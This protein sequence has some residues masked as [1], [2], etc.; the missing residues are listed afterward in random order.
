MF[1]HK[2]TLLSRPASSK[3]AESEFLPTWEHWMRHPMLDEKVGLVWLWLV[4]GERRTGRTLSEQLCHLSI[5]LT[6]TGAQLLIEQL[7]VQG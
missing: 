6:S 4:G 1:E 5:G 3:E 2:V 7:S